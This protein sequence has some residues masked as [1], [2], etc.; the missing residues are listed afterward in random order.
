MSREITL[1]SARDRLRSVG[2]E[3]A[4]TVMVLVTTSA[5]AKGRTGTSSVAAVSRCRGVAPAIPG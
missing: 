1:G 4:A 2:T 3:V 5:T